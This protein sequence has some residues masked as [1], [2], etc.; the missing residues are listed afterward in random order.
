MVSCTVRFFSP[1]F[2]SIEKSK[3]AETFA[4]LNNSRCSQTLKPNDNGQAV[5]SNESSSPRMESLLQQ[6]PLALLQHGWWW[7]SSSQPTWGSFQFPGEWEGDQAGE[8]GSSPPPASV[9]S[10]GG[11]RQVF[12]KGK[13]SVLAIWGHILG[14]KLKGSK[15]RK[16]SCFLLCIP[17]TS[18]T[19]GKNDRNSRQTPSSRINTEFC[20]GHCLCLFYRVSRDWETTTFIRIIQKHPT[21]QSVF[22]I[23]GLCFFFKVKYATNQ[24]ML[25]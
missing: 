14:S 17:A 24:S 23:A 16:L 2:P 19:I 4:E 15:Q 9:F 6:A 21:A 11:W 22:W 10:L 8:E 3:Q 20:C 12:Q 13:C 7:V 18:T 5:N 25:S 1:K